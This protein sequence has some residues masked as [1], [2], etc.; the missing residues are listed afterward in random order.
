M[1][2]EEIAN[3]IIKSS[4]R[5]AICIDDNYA[6]AYTPRSSDLSL[7]FDEPAELYTKFREEGCCDLDIFQYKNYEE[8]WKK[9]HML[10]NKDLLIIDWE[11]DP[12]NVHEK[13]HDTIKI[14]KDVVESN[15]IPFVVIYTNTPDLHQVD[16]ALIANF[17]YLSLDHF[18]VQ[19]QIANKTFGFLSIDQDSIDVEDTF[20]NLKQTFY[21]YVHFFERRPTLRKEIISTLVDSFQIKDEQIDKF[22][23]KLEALFRSPD[24]NPDF[25][26]NLSISVLNENVNKHSINRIEIN[27]HAYKINRTIVIIYHKQNEEDG[28]KP[29]NLFSEFAKAIINNPNNYLSLLSLEFKDRL[30]ENFSTIGTEFAGISEKA[31]LYHLNNYRKEDS[32]FD[33][34]YIYDF[35]LKSWINEL[36]NQ[37]MN[38]DSV[39]LSLLNERYD[40]IKTDIPD[41]GNPPFLK[42]LVRYSSFISNSVINNRDDLTLR[43]GDLFFNEKSKIFF[44]CITPLC[45]CIRPK[46][47]INDNF[48]FIQGSIGNDS[49]A[50]KNAE[51]DFYSFVSFSNGDTYSIKWK[52]KPFTAYITNNNINNLPFEYCG[53]KMELKHIS[54]LKENYAQRIANQ[55]FGYG[56][57]VGV[58]LPHIKLAD[59]AETSITCAVA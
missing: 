28:I 59:D 31:F 22:T 5:S 23:A 30:R 4:L 38:E 32:S 51:S 7:N 35:I 26:F 11:L 42:E 46:Q 33:I 52:C 17:N 19:C 56:F 10:F 18:K 44:L 41:P 40:L 37:K 9:D 20:D 27:Q 36:Y 55:S 3:S 24:D 43:F 15:K 39:S 49:E 14:L 13:Y 8:T 58:D 2:F 53:K 29:N 6:S 25:I 21:E 34:K 45:D 12:T 50:L 57:R 54:I 16:K 1:S 48:Y 47:K